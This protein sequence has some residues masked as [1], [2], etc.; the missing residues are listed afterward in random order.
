MTPVQLAEAIMRLV[1]DADDDTARCGLRI[2]AILLEHRTSARIEFER[3]QSIE[4]C[5]DD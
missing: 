1:G 5:R 4:D 3:T 2:A